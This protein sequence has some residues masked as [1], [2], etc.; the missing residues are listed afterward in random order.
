M[1]LKVEG[2]P[3]GC[4]ET[5]CFLVT[6]G[7]SSHR[8]L[9][10]PGCWDGSLKRLLL[11]VKEGELD[12]IL[13]TH[14]HFDHILG[15]EDV[16]ERYG[17]KIVIHE[18]DADCFVNKRKSLMRST[19]AEGKLPKK[20]DILVKDGD[21]LPF[22]SGFITVM[23]TPGHSAGSVCYLIDDL[24][25]SGDT[26]FFGSVGRT[27]FEY[28]CYEDIIKSVKRLAA[29]EGDRKVFPGHGMLTTLQRERKDNVFLKDEK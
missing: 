10:D 18:D 24:I 28:G 7:E 20:A 6:D 22:G 19:G 8:F 25:F 21:T 15:I 2:Y 4:I 3:V 9:V 23:H 17:G 1:K 14:G 27:D 11:G 5:N 29:L 16:R 12:Y 26:L 13:I